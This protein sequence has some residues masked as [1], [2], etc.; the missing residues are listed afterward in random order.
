M[1]YRAW[2]G[3]LGEKIAPKAPVIWDL[4][5]FGICLFLSRRSRRLNTEIY[6][7]CSYFDIAYVVG[8]V[9]RRFG[10][11]KKERNCTPGNLNYITSNQRGYSQGRDMTD[12]FIAV[13]LTKWTHQE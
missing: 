5:F 1:L 3:I 8:K 4:C 13:Y 9:I 10:K 2:T 7:H 11:E 6:G 12:E